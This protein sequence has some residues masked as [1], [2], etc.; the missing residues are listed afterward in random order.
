MK[1]I[2]SVPLLMV[3]AILG[4]QTAD[5]AIPARAQQAYTDG[6]Y[7]MA[8]TLCEAEGSGEAM[9][10]AAQARIADAITRDDGVCLECLV[11]AEETAQTAINR[12]PKLAEAYVQ[13]AVAMGF[14]GRLVSAMDA[15]AEG[16]AERGRAAIDKAL[17]L[18]PSNIWARA[19]LGGWHLEIVH[20]AGAFLAGALYGAHEDEGLKLF[21]EALADDPGSLVLRFHFALSI[22]ALDV[23]KYRGEAAQVLQDGYKDPGRDALGVL[24]RAHAEKL[25]DLLKTGSAKEIAALVRRFEGYPPDAS[26]SN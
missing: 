13:L 19:S 15:Q 21:R 12:D 24:T 9:A 17:E 23:E 5:A 8:A 26:A 10:F 22:L 1:V 2:R 18:E 14:H 7:I 3:C 4:A 16:L 25:R 20:R 6:R 11:R